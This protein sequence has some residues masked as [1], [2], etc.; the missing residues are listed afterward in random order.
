MVTVGHSF[1]LE[2]CLFLDIQTVCSLGFSLTWLAVLSSLFPD[3]SLS[4][5]PVIL[6]R[7]QHSVLGPLVFPTSILKIAAPSLH[8]LFL[9]PLPHFSPRHLSLIHYTFYFHLSSLFSV[10]FSP[11]CK[12][13]EGGD[14]HRIP[15][16]RDCCEVHCGMWNWGCWALGVSELSGSKTSHWLYLVWAPKA[17]SL[18]RSSGLGLYQW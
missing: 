4:T 13:P 8:P 14:D 16:E 3:S 18:E 17:H 1:L 6:R 9:P 15:F 2:I 10:F 7:S 12:L 11:T 5:Q